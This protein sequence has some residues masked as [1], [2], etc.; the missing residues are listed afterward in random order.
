MDEIVDKIYQHRRRFVGTAVMAVAATQLRMIG[1][2]AAQREGIKVSAIKPGTNTAFGPLKQVNA[3]VLNVGYAEA[4][5]AN[6]P[7][8][9]LLHGR[10]RARIPQR[11]DEGAARCPAGGLGAAA[12]RPAMSLKLARLA[13]S[14]EP[15]AE[16]QRPNNAAE[17]TP[18]IRQRPFA[19]LG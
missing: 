2:A 12:L 18:V 15:S 13:S 7:V 9:V 19:C 3:G 5:P 11:R 14:C 4:G 6:G 8:V 16:R 17:T 10:R 1:P